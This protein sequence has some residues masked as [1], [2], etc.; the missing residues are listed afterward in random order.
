MEGL[1]VEIQVMNIDQAPEVI[2]RVGKNVR[3][4][5]STSNSPEEIHMIVSEL[6]TEDEYRSFV[7]LWS[8]DEHPRVFD[9][10]QA[11]LIIKDKI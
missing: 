10:Q 1:M 7:N 9:Q 2:R 5:I 6:L 4:V 11:Y 8:N 3:V